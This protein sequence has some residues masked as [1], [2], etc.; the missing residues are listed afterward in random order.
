MQLIQGA[1]NVEQPRVAER[2]YQEGL[3]E[4]ALVFFDQLK[5][6]SKTCSCLLYLG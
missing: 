3:F 6:N 1:N 5:N 4:S 2:L